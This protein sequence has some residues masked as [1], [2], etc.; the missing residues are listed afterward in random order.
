VKKLRSLFILGW[1]IVLTGLPVF[2]TV[3]A[4]ESEV[5]IKN[6]TFRP[7]EI[8]VSL[9]ETVVWIQEDRAP[10]TVTAKDGGFDSGRL[11][12]GDKFP[13]T[14]SEKGVFGYICELHPSMTG[15]VIVK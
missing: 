6:F 7:K 14:F 8:V 3:M 10:H 15:K 9:G 11:G 13:Y 2:Y 12:K 4:A 1:V 5:T